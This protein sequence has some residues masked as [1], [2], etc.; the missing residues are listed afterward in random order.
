MLITNLTG[1]WG[2]GLQRW[3]KTQQAHNKKLVKFLLTPQ[4]SP[5]TTQSRQEQ[6]RKVLPPLATA[7]LP[8]RQEPAPRT[9]G[10]WLKFNYP[11]TMLESGRSGAG[12]NYWLYLPHRPAAR[13]P[14]V[15]MLHGCAQTAPQFAQSTGMN[16]LAEA[17]G[18][19]V[20]YPQQIARNHA[21]RC[22]RW[23]NPEVCQGEAETK[24]IAAI[25]DKVVEE[26]TLDRS[27]IYI[28]GISAGA[29]MAN[30][31]ALTYPHLV[32]A[33]G[34]H[35]GVAF[36]VAQTPM[37][38]YNLM[39]HGTEKDVRRAAH[40]L[41]T[42]LPHVP[43]MPAILI[44]GAEDSIV[45]PVNLG[46]LSEQFRELHHL[47]GYSREDMMVKIVDMQANE[48]AG[49]ACK[50]YEYYFGK[51]QFLQVC[52]IS[53]LGHAWSG[54]DG[55]VTFSDGCG[56]NASQMMWEFFSRHQ[57]LSESELTCSLPVPTAVDQTN[58]ELA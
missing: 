37:E 33:I 12:M 32:A 51:R 56:P 1:F 29:A 16:Q 46:Q 57:R 35:S 8:T 18:F 54:G 55:S 25:I 50:I 42:R 14:L 3:I 11:L 48:R 6:R 10:Q 58:I 15:V 19:A 26:H 2:A 9:K 5:R 47:A 36:G 21:G 31:L 28:A 44:H 20:L 38:G 17:E 13:M 39:Q 22:W 52:E 34:M 23:Y 4:T 41:A 7:L 40:D 49:R 45:S 30:I 43:L 53:E 27:R 24:A